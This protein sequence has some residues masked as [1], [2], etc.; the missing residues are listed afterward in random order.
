MARKCML[1]RDKKRRQLVKKYDAKRTAL[2]KVARDK[3]AKPEEIFV[4]TQ[5]L[6]KLPRSSAKNRLHNFCQ[7]TGRSRGV[8][9]KFK[10]CRIQIREL[11]SEGKIPGVRKSSW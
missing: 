10:L 2:L 11:A 4:A 6:A 8:Y 3:N 1:E 5:K 7:L 9:S